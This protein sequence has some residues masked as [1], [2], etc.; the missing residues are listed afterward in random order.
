MS[1]LLLL[2]KVAG[3]RCAF[4]AEDVQSVIETTT[5]TPVPLAPAHVAGLSALRSQ[6]L[7]VIDCRKAIGCKDAQDGV[8]PD[9]RAAVVSVDGHSYALLVDQV[10]DVT[11]ASSAPQAIP[12]GFGKAWSRVAHGMVET[13]S[14]PVLLLKTDTIVEGPSQS[15]AKAA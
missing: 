7:T 4:R 10:E 15:R 12:G 2:A 1:Q 9:L 13:G 14:G 5:I 11:E 6:A 8:E 3:R